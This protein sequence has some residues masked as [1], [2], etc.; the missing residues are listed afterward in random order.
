MSLLP[1]MFLVVVLEFVCNELRHKRRAKAVFL[2]IC[3]S[4]LG[5]LGIASRH[6]ERTI[7]NVTYLPPRLLH[8]FLAY[9]NRMSLQD[10]ADVRSYGV[11][12]GVSRSNP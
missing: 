6:H 9:R 10:I 5:G 11:Q 1:E 12:G 2:R 8:I 7:K 4:A 3:A